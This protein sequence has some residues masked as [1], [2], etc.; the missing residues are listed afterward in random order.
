MTRPHPNETIVASLAH[1]VAE[2]RGVAELLRRVVALLE[3]LH[4][5]QE[6]MDRRLGAIEQGDADA[7][8]GRADSSHIVD[9]SERD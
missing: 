7:D 5:R 2:V 4:E 3:T 9:T 1:Y 8:P 6:D